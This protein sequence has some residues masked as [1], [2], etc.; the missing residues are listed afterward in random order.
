MLRTIATLVLAVSFT[1]TAIAADKA[2]AS[3]GAT[4]SASSQ[5]RPGAGDYS[6]KLNAEGGA[7]S[8]DVKLSIKDITKDGRVTARVTATH[9][10]KACAASLPASGIVTKEGGMRLEVDAGVPE[11]CERIYNITSASGGS[12]QGTYIETAGRGASKKK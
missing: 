8:S 12:L 1:G 10:R 7:G 11:G 2:A 3:S 5:P 4:P 9:S 6:G